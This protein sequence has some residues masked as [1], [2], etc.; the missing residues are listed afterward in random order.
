MSGTTAN[1]TNKKK[2]K[3]QQAAGETAA[4][5][6]RVASARYRECHREQV[7]ASNRE[8]AAKHHARL[9][10]LNPGDDELEAARQRARESSARNRKELVA[11]QRQVRKRAFIHK[12]DLHAHI[13]RRF[14]APIPNCEP[15]S[16]PENDEEEDLSWGPNERTIMVQRCTPP[17][18]PS[19]GHE[20]RSAHN[21]TS[22]CVYYIVWAGQVHGVYTNS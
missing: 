14:D 13:Q 22:S 6:R 2:T 17:Y 7:L 16:E 15:E 12:Y 9:T 18:H 5:I 3:T 11:Q 21:T 10:A 4:R 19:A 20:D 1:T 8:H